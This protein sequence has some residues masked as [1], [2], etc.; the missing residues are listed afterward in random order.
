MRPGQTCRW[1]VWRAGPAASLLLDLTG[2]GR[3]ASM[4]KHAHADPWQGL[5][6]CQDAQP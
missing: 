2:P 3:H 1:Q 6:P 5:R 4:P